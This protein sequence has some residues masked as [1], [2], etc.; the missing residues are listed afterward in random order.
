M[1][2]DDV[3]MTTTTLMPQADSTAHSQ[4][5][6]LVT[7]ATY[8]ERDNLP[9][10][11]DAIQAALPDADILVIDD[12]SPDGTGRY[13]DERSAADKR[14]H[15]LHRAGKLGLGT[16]TIAG[17]RYAIEQNY[18]VMVNL[19]ADFSHHPRHLPALLT[20]LNTADVAIGSRYVPGGKVENWPFYRRAMSWCVNT[21]A[22]VLLGLR[23]RDVSGAYR[24]YKVEVLRPIDFD[25]IVS[26]GYSFQ[27]ELLWVLKRARASMV[28]VPITFADR[29]R[30]VSKINKSEALAAI[31][32]LFRL[33]IKNWLGIR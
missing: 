17:M 30:G 23:P 2:F 22:R 8:N 7:I 14:L 18:D 12:N 4:T 28:E 1:P 26:R 32:I 6:T 19:D 16:A 25:R 9:L 24:A 29:E 3:D 11:L 27:E 13:C 21:Y 5:R 10:L 31:A 20:G 15:C 33:G